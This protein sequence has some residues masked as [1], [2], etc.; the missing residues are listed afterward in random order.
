[1]D[2]Q[3]S[4]CRLGQYPGDICPKSTIYTTAVNALAILFDTFDKTIFQTRWYLENYKQGLREGQGRFS[5]VPRI[6]V[7]QGY[8]GSCATGHGQGLCS[9][10][11]VHQG[12][13]SSL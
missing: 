2:G 10:N 5:P 7:D 1:M 4:R 13:Q 9:W 12:Q 8:S 6:Q 3:D 11:P